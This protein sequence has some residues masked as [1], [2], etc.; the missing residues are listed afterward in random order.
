MNDNTKKTPNIKI[1]D[2][3]KEV[4]DLYKLNYRL[5]IKISL[6][7]FLFK[8][9]SN[10][11]NVFQYPFTDLKFLFLY[12]LSFFVIMIPFF[13]YITKFSIV[14]FIAISER[15]KKCNID[16]K[17]AYKK[18]SKK[19]WR[20]LGVD[21]RFFLLLLL[22][23]MGAITAYLYKMD[24]IIK[25]LLIG[26]FVLLTI[27]LSTVYG[28]A[29]LISIIGKM[30]NKFFKASKKLVQGDFLKIAFLISGV[31]LVFF[32]PYI[33]YLFVFNDYNSIPNINRFV[34]SLINQILYVFIT[35]LLSSISVV[36]YYTLIRNKPGYALLKW[37]QR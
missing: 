11:I 37:D 36:T 35:P 15:Y 1:I 30:D 18:S 26:A 33:L 32:I 13:F 31:M 21:L 14:L 6:I 17:E 12:K 16:I 27:Y 10:V 24:T 28:F 25:Y 20:Y 2:I 9:L 7:I 22:S 23:T 3:F 34:V 4:I 19:F 29:S 5:F 8:F